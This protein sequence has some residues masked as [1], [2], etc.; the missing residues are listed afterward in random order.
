MRPV[1]R[2]CVPVALLLLLARVIDVRAALALLRGA[3]VEWIAAGLLLVQLQI[4]ASALRWRWTAARLGQRIGARRAMAE[5]YLASLVN[6]T[7]PGGVTGDAA[8]AVRNAEGTSLGTAGLAV[9]AERV[10]GQAALFAVTL[11]GLACWPALVAGDRPASSVRAVALVGVGVAASILL[12]RVAGR[13]GPARVRQ[14]MSRLR[15]ALH[16]AWVAD[17]A[18]LV[19]GAASLAIVAGYLAL[20]AAC[21]LALGA[22]LPMS[23]L[24]TVVPLALLTMLLPV[25]IGGWGLREAASAALW[26]LVGLTAESG[27]ATSVL[28]GLVALAGSLPGLYVAVSRRQRAQA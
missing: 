5:Y 9:F 14:A 22:P 12:V 25:S 1:L 21:G 15:A 11:V 23:A 28:Y 17:G 27:L 13:R 7:L 16:L 8:R 19:Q 20:Y 10:S 26:P 3:R 18:W 6:Q 24:V 4:V 2:T